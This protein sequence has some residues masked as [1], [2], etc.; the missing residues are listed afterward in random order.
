MKLA[1]A[2]KMICYPEKKNEA[3]TRVSSNILWMCMHWIPAFHSANANVFLS[4][5]LSA[6]PKTTIE[7]VQG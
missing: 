4:F 6:I 3:A 7:E 2:L 1:T 5:F